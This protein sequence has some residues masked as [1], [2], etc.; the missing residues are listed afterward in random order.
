MKFP[1]RHPGEEQLLSYV[2]GELS[3]QD[4]DSVG[5]HL[6]SCWECRST[7]EEFQRI[8]EECVR[9]RKAVLENCFPPPPAPW[10]DIHERFA[11][12]DA[13]PGSASFWGRAMAWLRPAL[14]M[15]K[16]WT[17]AAAA[18]LLALF[19]ID[20]FR[21]APAV[22]AA[23]LLR[24]AVSTEAALASKPRTIQVRTRTRQFTRPAYLPA[25]AWHA[26]AAPRDMEAE[27]ALASKLERAGYSWQNPLSAQAFAAWRNQLPSK[28]DEVRSVSDNYQIRTTTDSGEL[29]SATIH[30]R[31]HDLNAVAETLQFR[32][33]AVE[34]SEVPE[35]PTI[36]A[37][38][39]GEEARPSATPRSTI[40]APVEPEAA[41]PSD[42]LRVFALLRGA[43]AD[44]GE[45]IEVTRSGPNVVV[46]GVGVSKERQSS[47][48]EQLSLLPRV[49][50]DF[51]EPAVEPEPSRSRSLAG[52]AQVP[53]TSLLAS[54][55]ERQ[56]GGR[57]SFEQFADQIL[58][59]SEALLARAH[60]LRR[61][62]RRF[63]PEAEARLTPSE[64]QLLLNLLRSHA[65]ELHEKA[66][67]IEARTGPVLLAL[68]AS[69]PAPATGRPAG[70]WQAGAEDLL[71]Q[72]R[73]MDSNLAVMLG[74]VAGEPAE[75][76]L[77]SQ[78]VSSLNRL[79]FSAEAYLALTAAP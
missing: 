37:A 20:Q 50:V 35:S 14:R 44:L 51:S 4:A 16:T 75:Q 22:R 5:A 17:P 57:A 78:L 73:R 79:T 72:A 54:D 56:L 58:D 76:D 69:K 15:S 52:Q 63:T 48:T 28:H 1:A 32:D 67:L 41:T 9:Y 42:E 18:L 29:V 21:N 71:S 45:P 62:S 46:T 49:K 68:G 30:L 23:E 2:D 39:V 59:W 77:K 6:A 40:A 60:A 8:I 25:R 55:I 12:L 74:V 7:L 11:S 26:N 38:P 36:A 61:L 66:R 27:A 64:K 33:E 10:C 31:A 13:A 70:N 65:V 19:A 24:K 3:A 43:G 34:I 47:L 53:Q